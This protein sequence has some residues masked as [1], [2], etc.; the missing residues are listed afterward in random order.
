MSKVATRIVVAKNIHLWWI[1]FEV[2]SHRRNTRGREI[3]ACLGVVSRNNTK[4]VGSICVLVVAR[5]NTKAIGRGIDIL[6]LYCV[7]GPSNISNVATD[8]VVWNK[9]SRWMVMIHVTGHI[10]SRSLVLV[11]RK[12]LFH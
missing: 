12:I 7:I 1:E 9:N 5:S 6:E 4:A 11:G 3:S 10:W 8:V 2:A